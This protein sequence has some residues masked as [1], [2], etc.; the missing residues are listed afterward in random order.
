MEFRTH[1][2]ISPPDF[3]IDHS[4][5]MMLFGSCFSEH[6]GSKLAENKF[7]VDVNPFG[8]L[9]NPMSVSAALKR[10]I[11]KNAI[12]LNDLVQHNELYHSL[13]HHGS[14]SHP[15]KSVC[16]EN[17]SY[18]FDAATRSI[19]HTDIFFVTLGTAYVYKWKETGEIVGNCHKF[20]AELFLRHR[21]SVDEVVE[22]WKPLVEKLLKINPNAKVIFTVSPIRHW[23][24]GAHENQLSKSILHLSIDA[25]Q[26][27]F[28]ENVLYFPAYEIILDELRDY[29]FYAEDMMH[30][31]SVAVDYVWERFSETYFSEST[32]LLMKEW[33]R[34]AQDLRHRPLNTEVAS[35]R[36]FLEQTRR[37]LQ[38][39]S[40]NYPQIKCYDELKKLETLLKN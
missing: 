31:S 34:I 6:I 30:P 19:Q 18:R 2:A 36:S 4:M 33:G 3:C 32:R 27:I 29:R 26:H 7:Q 38:R 25:L 37:K 21:V 11:A 23:K 15:D 35:Y 22:E 20:P 39:F 5:R 13:M 17:I 8:I 10:I 1:I 28:S 12:T 14:F 40:T 16:V 9:Y 24:D